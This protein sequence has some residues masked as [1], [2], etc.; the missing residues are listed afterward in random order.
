MPLNDAL[1]WM[2]DFIRQTDR[3]HITWLLL[4][5]MGAIGLIFM[6]LRWWLGHSSSTT[7]SLYALIPMRLGNKDVVKITFLDIK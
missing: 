3:T 6:G 2:V 4:P 7:S 1:Q 5:L